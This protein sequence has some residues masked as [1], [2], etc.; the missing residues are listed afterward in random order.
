MVSSGAPAA[1]FSNAITVGYPALPTD[2]MRKDYA[3]AYYAPIG[4]ASGI[5]KLSG[6]NLYAS[7]TSYNVGIGTAAPAT[8]L[9]VNGTETT[10]R[11]SQTASGS[12]YTELATRSWGGN[13]AIFF[14]AYATSSYANGDFLYTGNT[15][16]KY[17][18]SAFGSADHRAKAIITDH[19]GIGLYI[20]G[21]SGGAGQDVTWNQ[22][23]LV[24]PSNV[25]IPTNNVGIGEVSP[26]SKLS[27]S[28]GAT[29]G[30][31]YDT[32]AAPTNGLLVEGLVGIGTNSPGAYKLNVQA[33]AAQTLIESTS[34]A[35]LVLK[36]GDA[37]T[38]ILF[39]DSGATND[40]IWYNGA[41][42]TFA[43]GGGGASV[44]GK[45]LHVDGGM[46]IGANY[47]A[48]V[49]GTN[50]LSV[51]G[52][53]S[54]GGTFSPASISTASGTF[55]SAANPGP[56]VSIT[57]TL[58]SGSGVSD[59]YALNVTGS[60]ASFTNGNIVTSTAVYA[61]GGNTAHANNRSYALQAIAGTGAGSEYAGYFSGSVG[62]N[63]KSPGYAL[64]VVG[65][66]Q[67]QGW[68][69]TTGSNGWYSQTYGGGWNMTDTTWI[70]SYGSK[71]VYIDSS[72]R[73]DGGII[74]GNTS[75]AGA[76]TIVTTSSTFSGGYVGG[77]GT[78]GT[79]GA[80][81]NTWRFGNNGS[82]A[83][84]WLY[85]YNGSGS[86]YHDLALGNLWVSGAISNVNNITQVAGSTSTL[87]RVNAIASGSGWDDGLNLYSNDGT[88]R[89]N[90]LVDNGATDSMRIAYNSSEV[91][92]MNTG[93]NVGIGTASPDGFQVNK[94]TSETADST[95]NVRLGIVSGT[96]RIIFEDSGSTQW[97]ID[98]AGGT[99]RFFNPGSVVMSLTTT[100]TLTVNKINAA[101]VDP[102]YTI[103][104]KKYA[105]YMAGMT[106]LKEETTG[107]VKLKN[108]KAVL[109]LAG[110]SENSDLWLFGKTININAASYIGEDGKVYKTSEDKILDGVVVLLTP[111]F[112]GRV[113]YEKKDGKILISSSEKTGEIS[114][115][116]TAP[117]FDA[118]KKNGNLRLDLDPVEGLNL[119]KLLK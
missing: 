45:K 113:W 73:A 34:D 19:S 63:T 110:S 56:V 80:Y 27:V 3:D 41:N 32:T 18:A 48:T 96:P 10:N 38:G 28:G 9:D 7:S 78:T 67:V 106:G 71:S 20:S 49:M 31:T 87:R 85:L 75:A 1:I 17:A 116:L 92:H 82:A 61:V 102:P 30:A 46:T 15:K 90:Y 97:Q 59:Y 39:D 60:S 101:E 89:W 76:G 50:G 88:N 23:F 51:E 29:I 33:G 57:N 77:A 26:G 37:W 111:N 14:G 69:R 62:I 86:T 2:A 44:A 54:V 72:L 84:S 42:G 107:V 118:M 8:K 66:A 104:G 95:D 100:G 94:T 83:N 53:L 115:R 68:L 105:T 91:M 24:T 43:V 114:Y 21:V 4:G 16:H 6:N 98:N 11:I 65:D 119:D 40:Y 64:D 93:G 25:Y 112:D 13:N 22:E 12:T 117:R 70:R 81:G 52:N 109:D 74:S 55:S 35:Q 36:S 47:D 79:A 99:L 108:N 58:D 103:G 5:W